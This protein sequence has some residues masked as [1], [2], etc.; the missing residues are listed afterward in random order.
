MI[1]VLQKD[2]G[3]HYNPKTIDPESPM[4]SD[5]R[6]IHSLLRGKGGS[7]AN[8]PVLYAAVGRRLGYPIYICM[9][10][11][12]LYCRWQTQDNRERFNIEGSDDENPELVQSLYREIYRLAATADDNGTQFLLIDSDLVA[13]GPELLGFVERRLAG[14]PNAPSLIPYYNGP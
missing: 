4:T 11:S 1:T 2:F 12:H 14:E 3:V 5:E 7:C 6:F 9:A 10:R 8:M 13:P